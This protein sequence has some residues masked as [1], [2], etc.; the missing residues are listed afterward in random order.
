MI[1]QNIS[2]V[3]GPL[4]V[5]GGAPY[6]YEHWEAG[7]PLYGYILGAT[8]GRGRIT[9]I[10]TSHAERAPGVQL[11]LTYRNAPAKARPTLVFLSCT[12][13]RTRF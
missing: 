8:I 6:A 11:V 9:A 3:D 1:G 12:C 7:Q 13:A 4:K 2:R 10:D 5:S